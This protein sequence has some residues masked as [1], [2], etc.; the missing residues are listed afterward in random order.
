MELLEQRS[1]LSAISVSTLADSVDPA[2]GVTSLREAVA[3]ANERP[4]DDTITF[5]A[6]LYA[7]QPNVIRL[8]N[9]QL[10]ISDT[11]GKTSIIGPGS[12][13]LQISG[14]SLDR[15]FSIQPDVDAQI[16]GLT[17]T[18]GVAAQGGAVFNSGRLQFSD[19]RLTNNSAEGA[20]G[21]RGTKGSDM[22]RTPDPGR[23]GLA[24]GN[25]LDA[26]GGAVFND[27]DL[28]IVDSLFS[29]NSAV[30]GSGG[31]GGD[32]GIGGRDSIKGYPGGRGGQGGDGGSA[33]GGAIFN[34]A[35]AT[36]HVE[37]TG[38]AGNAAIGGDGGAGGNGGR[39]G[40]KKVGGP[41]GNGG[42]AGDSGD[43]FGGGIYNDGTLAVRSLQF[44]SGQVVAGQAGS[45]GNGGLPGAGDYGQGSRGDD[46]S[47]GTAGTAQSANIH[48]SFTELPE[49]DS[50]GND[51][52]VYTMSEAVSF[53][54]NNFIDIDQAPPSSGTI[55]LQF[56][57][58]QTQNYG[59][60]LG[61]FNHAASGHRIYLHIKGADLYARLGSGNEHM[62]AANVADG[63][64]HSVGFIYGSTANIG[65]A[66][67]YVDGKLG[68]S[69][70]PPSVSLV[71]TP[72]FMLGA[73]PATVK[74]QPQLHFKGKIREV[75]V[76]DWILPESRFIDDPAP[77]KLPDLSGKF[78]QASTAA[79]QPGETISVVYEIQNEGESRADSFKVNFYVS[80]D[81]LITP[82]DI[83]LHTANISGLDAEGSTGRRTAPLTL[84]ADFSSLDDFFTIGMLVDAADDISESDESN[85]SNVGVGL[86]KMTLDLDTTTDS[87]LPPT[88]P[89]ADLTVT[90]TNNQQPT[91]R[92]EAVANAD[93]Y[94]LWVFNLDTGHRVIHQTS[95]RTTSFQPSQDI[96][97]GRTVVWVRAGNAAGWG[98]WSNAERIFIGLQPPGQ[99]EVYASASVSEP[100]P[101]LSWSI[102]PSA[103]RYELW[104]NH[105]STGN[106]AIHKTD[107][108]SATFTPEVNLE[109]GT[110]RMWVRAINEAG[111]GKWS[112]PADFTVTAST[113]PQTPSLTTTFRVNTPRPEFSWEG[114]TDADVYELWVHDLATGQ[115]I[116]HRND[117]HSETYVPTFDLNGGEYRYWVRAGNSVGW[118]EWSAPRDVQVGTPP[119][120]VVLTE[121][122][123]LP[124]GRAE[125]S[126]QAATTADTYELWVNNSDTGQLVL[127]ERN[128]TATSFESNS[129]LPAGTYTVWVRAH[130][131]SGPGRWSDSL[132]FEVTTN[133][134]LPAVTFGSQPLSGSTTFDAHVRWNSVFGGTRYEFRIE[135]IRAN[136][137]EYQYSSTTDQTMVMVDMEA[138]GL[139]V[140]EY[141]LQVRAIRNAT[142]GTWSSPLKFYYP[143]K[144]PVQAYNGWIL[145]R[146]T[147]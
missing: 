108:T 8:T 119:T 133:S 18:D 97:R 140:G 16:S 118:S 64:W 33:R 28:R 61:H 99:V 57:T 22:T 141:S 54:G 37:D 131:E 112:R 78:F 121:V 87:P 67:V 144:W 145:G 34:S 98:T 23:P 93:R 110:Y 76:Y 60:I 68:A 74:G 122:T 125:I 59:A 89:P 136:N 46:G 132:K 17:L 83:L 85:N 129:P 1:L 48:G 88:S 5:D 69:F 41:G 109:S 14:S 43:A 81:G 10:E 104:V 20:E 111:F 52:P 146:N 6:S 95:L 130:N 77:V 120:Q 102:D 27:G 101:P 50:S 58:N 71:T 94:E 79:V 113:A 44:T 11:A 147:D 29:E 32:G 135:G 19:V 42:L 82:D 55:L 117:L 13:R 72:E 31:Q 3:A 143:G 15:I 116:I 142:V 128:L 63:Q 90:G 9:G 106:L 70:T 103:Q 35:S 124:N 92:W 30:G 51:T 26:A 24:A 138:A 56:Q 4:G 84:P 38:F 137:I 96:S 134:S 40:S 107:L 49:D 127:H 114:S 45:P 39:G 62:V 126:W 100:R 73:T 66:Q 105:V 65:S 123:N 80:D 75:E 21:R 86:D 47:S 2:D 36:L 139:R 12:E 25:G 53:N 115:K 7:D 91:F